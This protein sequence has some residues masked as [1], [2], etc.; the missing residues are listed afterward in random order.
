MLADRWA[1][2]CEVGLLITD[3]FN[4]LQ[5]F[6]YKTPQFLLIFLLGLG[7]ILLLYKRKRSEGNDSVAKETII[8]KQG[9]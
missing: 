1:Y 5:A 4:L 3:G 2:K 7:Y 9:K 6:S 8:S